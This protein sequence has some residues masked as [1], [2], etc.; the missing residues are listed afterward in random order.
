M[1]KQTE[2][3]AYDLVVSL[4]DKASE[5][6]ESQIIYPIQMSEQEEVDFNLSEKCYMCGNFFEIVDF[7]MMKVRDHDHHKKLDNYRGAACISCNAILQDRHMMPC[8]AHNLRAY[9]SHFI[10]KILN[11]I[12]PKNITVV[13]QN[14][15]C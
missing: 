4:R 8:F 11:Q 2:N 9:D 10:V 12:K 5:L 3:A 14:M 6:F 7:K 1:V 13:P 15:E